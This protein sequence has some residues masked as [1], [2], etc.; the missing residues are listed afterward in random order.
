[1]LDR[2]VLCHGSL[3]Y[4]RSVCGAPHGDDVEAHGGV[5]MDGRA[6]WRAARVPGGDRSGDR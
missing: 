3:R 4:H 2:A 1:M 5:R 6:G